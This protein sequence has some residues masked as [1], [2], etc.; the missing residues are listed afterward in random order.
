MC[1]ANVKRSLISATA[2]STLIGTT[3]MGLAANM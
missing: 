1:V 3:I 2:I